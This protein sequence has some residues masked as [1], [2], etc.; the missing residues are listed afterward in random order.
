MKA[1]DPKYCTGRI[2]VIKKGV[3]IIPT[4]KKNVLPEIWMTF[5]ESIANQGTQT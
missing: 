5:L 2:I 1:A 3:I 4:T